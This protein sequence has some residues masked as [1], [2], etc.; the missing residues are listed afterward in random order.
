M[1]KTFL[2]STSLAIILLASCT[3]TKQ[4]Q[5]ITEDS[6]Q[7]IATLKDAYA[8]LSQISGVTE[9]TI[10]IIKFSKYEVKVENNV[11]A[12]NLNREQ[13]KNTG[14]AMLSILDRVPM[15]Y[16]VN[17][18][19]NNL[20]A[21]FVYANQLSEDKNEVLIVACSGEAGMY[22]ASYGIANDSTVNALRMSP[23]SMQGQMFTLTLEDTPN[24]Q[25][26]L[27]NFYE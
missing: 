17:G 23:L 22:S 4:S 24:R 11:G 10:P 16:I 14:N 13:I 1:M 18:A 9:D 21:G 19:T 3:H 5:P 25:I 12:T 27:I 20:A 8:Q 6:K 26:Y 15:E 7:E 2:W